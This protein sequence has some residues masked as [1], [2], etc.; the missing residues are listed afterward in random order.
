M[1]SLDIDVRPVRTAR[2]QRTFLTF[3]WRIYRDD[4]LWVPPLLPERAKTIDPERGAFFKRGGEAEFF[5]A[6]RGNQPVG[7][8]CAAE[9]AFTNEQRGRR[10]CLFGFLE[11]VEDYVVFEALLRRVVAWAGRRNLDALLGPFNLDYEDSYGVLIEGRDRPPALLCGHTPPYYQQFVE[12][13]GF[14]PARG[15][16]LAYEMDTDYSTPARKRVF[17]LAERVRRRSGITVRGADL[18][19]WDEEIDRVYHLINIALS[20]LPDFIGWHR[21]ALEAALMPFRDIVD[22]ELVL[23]AEVGGKVVG[24]L[25]GIPNLNEAFIHA[26]GLRYPWDYAK[27]WWHMRRQ[28]ECLAIKS[29]L[30]LPE[31]WGTG[32]SVLLF[33]EMGKRASAR[34]YKW[35]DLSLTSDDNPNTPILADRLGAV[36]YKRYRVYRYVARNA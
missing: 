19:H 12:R 16:N 27:L 8:I 10:E 5:I 3:P 24:W 28:A 20:H 32:V 18:A 9:D 2:E 21:D 11:Y 33:A 6:W 25:P 26:N 34:G 14:Q 4:P 17:Y 30:I 13:F 22:P 29:V 1:S 15:D 31:Y 7:T 23:F 36:V 35:L